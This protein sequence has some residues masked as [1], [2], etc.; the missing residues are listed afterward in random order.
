VWDFA[1][2]L[3]KMGIKKVPGVPWL[4]QRLWRSG[5]KAGQTK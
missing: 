4:W 2:A 3:I 1:V 5:G